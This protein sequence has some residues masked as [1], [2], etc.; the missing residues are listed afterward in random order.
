MLGSTFFSSLGV[1][2]AALAL[3][4]CGARSA[5][6]VGASDAGGAPSDAG[7]TCVRP[8]SAP[9]NPTGPVGFTCAFDPASAQEPAFA[10]AVGT[11]LFETTLDGNTAPVFQ[12]FSDVPAL[13]AQPGNGEVAV[14]SRGGFYGAVH[15]A[16]YPAAGGGT[17]PTTARVEV[18]VRSWATHRT[19]FHDAFDTPYED[20]GNPLAAGVAIHADDSGVFAYGYGF[21][22]LGATEIVAVSADGQPPERSGFFQ[23]VVPMADPDEQGVV[24]VAY[25]DTETG[26]ITNAWLD[27][28]SGTTPITLEVDA[29]LGS[30]IVSLDTKGGTLLLASAGAQ[31][32]IGLPPSA[33]EYGGWRIY[34]VNGSGWVLLYDGAEGFLAA[35]VLTGAV[36]PLPVAIPSGLMRLAWFTQNPGYDASVGEVHVTSDGSLLMPLQT[37]D[38]AHL[39]RLGQDGSWTAIGD[40]LGTLLSASGV[41]AGGTY[42]GFASA[43]TVMPLPVW[44]PSGGPRVDGTSVTLARPASSLTRVLEQDGMNSW[45]N[46]GYAVT[47]DG[48]CLSYYAGAVLHVI[49]TTTGAETTFD[50]SA[51]AGPEP[52]LTAAPSWYPGPA[53]PLTP[54]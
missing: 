36:A 20:F 35:D 30:R 17:E 19:V 49:S 33:S 42:L 48:G 24:A 29:Y 32:L 10:I 37:A 9:F 52:Y 14:T 18:I 31:Q 38:A 25:S 43:Y 51:S 15:W 11:T 41:E 13:A 39:Y 28:C 6:E 16:T 53:S 50:H 40:A 2:A 1:A 46:T 22:S 47:A 44:P 23:G 8:L 5:L 54:N 26:S 34:D 3:S 7:H 45:E 4:G 27:P 21:G 12:F